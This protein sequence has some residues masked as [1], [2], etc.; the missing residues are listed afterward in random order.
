MTTARPVA[1]Q[2]GYTIHA[3]SDVQLRYTV[4]YKRILLYIHGS[5]F[6]TYPTMPVEYP[7]ITDSNAL[8]LGQDS[9]SITTNLI[10]T[11]LDKS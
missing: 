8:W 4:N 5:A 3:D 11:L 9:R 2:L 7:A 1:Q 10:T 6:Q